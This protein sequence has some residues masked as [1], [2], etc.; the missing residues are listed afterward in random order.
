MD[1]MSLDRARDKWERKTS[2][3]GQRWRDAV[4]GR[5]SDYEQGVA[6]FL[7]V[8]PDQITTGSTWNQ[9]VQA[10]SASDYDA[11]VQGKGQKWAE[12]YRR[13]VTQG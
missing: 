8:S 9:E 6:D 2:G 13:G 4:E 1:A 12:N 7:G 10:V 5:Q 3:A 11:A